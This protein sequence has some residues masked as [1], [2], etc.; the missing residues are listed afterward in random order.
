[1]LCK[2]KS[3]KRNAYSIKSNFMGSL[4]SAPTFFLQVIKAAGNLAELVFLSA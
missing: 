1:M 2:T 3:S 4:Y